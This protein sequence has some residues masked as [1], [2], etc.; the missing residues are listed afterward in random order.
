M[1]ICVQL[2]VQINFICKQF[3]LVIYK[4]NKASKKLILN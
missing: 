3:E 1:I 4:H 2:Q